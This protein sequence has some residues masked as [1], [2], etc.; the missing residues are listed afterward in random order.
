[1]AIILYPPTIDW[2]WMKQRP[3]QLMQSLARLG[4]T[5]YYCNSTERDEPPERLE[6]RLTVI[7]NHRRWVRE[8]WPGIRAGAAGSI[9]VWCTFP[10]LAG[11]LEAY[12]ADL[13]V[14]DCIDEFAEWHLYEPEMIARSDALSCSS[15]RLFR[16]LN[17]LYPHKPVTLIRNGY[18][19]DMGL[20]VGAEYST[21]NL[22]Q[23]QNQNQNRDRLPGRTGPFRTIGYVGAW[24]PWVDEALVR[25]IPRLAPDI[26]VTV[27]GPEFGR[28]QH[29]VPGERIRFLGL[30][31]HARLP[32]LIRSMEVCIVPFRLTPVTLSTNPVKVY[33][34]L[35]AGRP[36]VSTALPEC[37]LLQPHVDIGRTPEQFLS[38]IRR[39]LDDPGDGA[40]RVAMALEHTWRRRAEQADALIR[41]QLAEAD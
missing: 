39:R 31:P 8:S 1:M 24:A 22:N 34:Y 23:Y 36:V 35:A 27:V 14:Y 40:A 16:R 29:A 11:G 13:T 19:P 26:E 25:R 21:A 5:V 37:E 17:R 2:G 3:Q 12:G 15:E 7:H 33:E 18:D 20:H 30:Q 41:Q 10:K 9:V 38:H 28:K 6:E 32:A 4:H